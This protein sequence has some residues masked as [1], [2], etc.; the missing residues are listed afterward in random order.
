MQNTAIQEGFSNPLDTEQQIEKD[1]LVT[2]IEN[3]I[4][5]SDDILK[6]PWDRSYTEQNLYT[7]LLARTWSSLY[8]RSMK[9]SEN[10][11]TTWEDF[12]NTFKAKYGFDFPQWYEEEELILMFLIFSDFHYWNNKTLTDFFSESPLVQKNP[13]II[14]PLEILFEKITQQRFP[15]KEKDV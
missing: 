7:K 6:N 8:V 4:K 3:I 14:R 15:R 1:T 11:L 10:Q 9:E 12:K 13:G 5:K 2:A